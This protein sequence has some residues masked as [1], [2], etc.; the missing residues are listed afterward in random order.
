MGAVTYRGCQ[1]PRRCGGWPGG[2]VSEPEWGEEGIPVCVCV[3]K[4]GGREGEGE[5]GADLIGNCIKVKKPRF[6]H[7]RRS[8]RPGKGESGEASC[9][10]RVRC[11]VPLCPRGFRG[12]SHTKSVCT[13]IRVPGS[14]PALVTVLRGPVTKGTYHPQTLASMDRAPGW[15]PRRH[16]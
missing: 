6:S 1:H 10:L 13:E 11:E 12:K 14:A 7:Q 9:G 5:R 15:A 16:G 3:C 8:C 2:G 4:G